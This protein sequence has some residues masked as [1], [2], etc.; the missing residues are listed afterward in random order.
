MD[1]LTAYS[2][3]VGIVKKINQDALS[4]K[5]VNSPEGKILF[6][7]VCDGMG[8][9]EQGELASKEVIIAF[10]NW[11]VT[12]FADMISKDTFSEETVRK[13][14]QVLVS[15]ANRRLGDYAEDRGMMMGTTLS[16]LLVF[17]GQYFICHVGD[18]RI[19]EIN[20]HIRQITTDHSLVAQEVAMGRL[21]EEEA[22]VD[23][24]RSILLQCVGASDVIQPQ[25]ETGILDF[26]TTF[27][28]ASD[29]FV[30]KI[31]EDELFESFRPDTIHSKEELQGICDAMIREVLERGERDNVTVVAATICRDTI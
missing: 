10:N 19:Y 20:H 22:K 4:V 28:L 12:S 6:A 2:T 15:E 8:G 9:L 3:T 7:L 31:S 30:H 11:F 16:V 17:Q 29:G 27:L 14:W 5:V 13:Q 23:P 1:I 25:F 21:T 26:S 24:R 18:S